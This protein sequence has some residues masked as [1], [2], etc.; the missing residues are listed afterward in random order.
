[1]VLSST[2]RPSDERGDR[3]V[4]LASGFFISLRDSGSVYSKPCRSNLD[5]P[6][7]GSRPAAELVRIVRPGVVYEDGRSG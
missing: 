5:E 2:N 4:R 1:M 6:G 3:R 7:S